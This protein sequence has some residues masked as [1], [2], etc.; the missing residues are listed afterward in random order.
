MA[1][2]KGH[3]WPSWEGGLGAC[4]PRKFGFQC[5]WQYSRGWPYSPALV[6]CSHAH[7]LSKLCKRVSVNTQHPTVMIHKQMYT[8]HFI[9]MWKGNCTVDILAQELRWRERYESKV[10]CKYHPPEVAIWWV[11]QCLCMGWEIIDSCYIAPVAMNCPARKAPE[12]ASPMKSIAGQWWVGLS[13]KTEYISPARFQLQPKH[14]SSSCHG[15]R[16]LV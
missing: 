10:C 1:A 13:H 9:N 2:V 5:F 8:M 12:T 7:F 3:F 14:S 16:L 11:I 6:S 4:Y 15:Y